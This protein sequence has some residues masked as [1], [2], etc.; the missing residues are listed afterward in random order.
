MISGRVITP[1]GI[2]LRYAVSILRDRAR[3]L[4]FLIPF[5][6]PTSIARPFFDFF[7]THF[8]IVTLES[9][10]ILEESER[11][12]GIEAFSIADHVQD[13]RAVMDAC[14][15]ERSILVGY[16]SGAGIALAAAARLPERFDSLILAHG[17]YAILKDPACVTRFSL[18]MDSLLSLAAKDERHANLVFEKVRDRRVIGLDRRPPGLD[19]PFSKLSYLRRYAHNYIAYKS[20]DFEYLARP[21]RQRALLLSGERDIQAN[22]ASTQRIGRALANSQI[23]VDRYSDHYGLLREESDSLTTI[24]NYLCD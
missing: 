17:E 20:C 21:V 16:C 2:Q 5:G 6:L 11:L 3:W 23:H 13:V 1:D 14:C 24:W 9:R 10:C 8:N 18:E 7:G 12:H 15:I 4:T 19:L 22:V